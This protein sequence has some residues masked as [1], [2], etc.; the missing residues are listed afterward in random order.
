MVQT[1]KAPSLFLDE[2]T[3]QRLPPW[4]SGPTE[5]LE[6]QALG[7]LPS[8][9]ALMLVAPGCKQTATDPNFTSVFNTGKEPV[10]SDP[11]HQ[12]AKALP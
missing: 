8:S 5:L 12:E 3:R 11:F 10:I 7:S 1:N 9:P 4:L 6:T 2:I